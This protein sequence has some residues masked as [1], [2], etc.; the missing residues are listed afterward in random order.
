MDIQIKEATSGKDRSLFLKLP[1]SLHS[2]HELWVPPLRMREKKYI[3]PGKNIHIHYSDTV[4]Y[5][6]FADGR[7]VGRIMGIINRKLNEIWNDPHARFCSFECINNR[8]AAA[9]L[10]GEVESWSKARNM[11]RLVGPLGFSNQDPQGFLIEGFDQRS[12]I[13]TIYNY[14]YIPT[15]MDECGY[16]KEVD[17]VTYNIPIPETIPPLYEKIQDRVKNRTAVKMLEFTSKK[18]ARPWLSTILSFMNETYSGIYGFLPLSEEIIRKTA[19]TYY[20]IMDPN[21]LKVIVDEKGNIVSFIFGIKDITGGFQKANGKLLPFGY[22]QIKSTQKK[23]KRLD[24]LLGAIKKEYRGKGLNTL[25][26]IAI[27]KSAHHAGISYADS[28]HELE[29]NNMV[30]AEMK[31]LGGSIYKRHR[32]YRKL[33]GS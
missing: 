14:E 16:T 17:Y 5:L 28:H 1:Y 8:E 18:E 23:S 32:V 13:G 29:S 3:D 22:F 9:A 30:Q 2:R 10:L 33:L 21:F 19:R 27:I 25:M 6:A 31:R 7:P 20:E 24:L 12:S 26:A 11:E 4:C 15:L